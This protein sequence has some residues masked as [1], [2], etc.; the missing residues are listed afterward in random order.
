MG[1]RIRQSL[2]PPQKVAKAREE[3]VSYIHES[4][5]YTKVPRAKAKT[6]G[7]K[8]I[9]VRWIDINKGDNV[10]ENYRSRLVAREIKKDGRPDLFAATPTLE[11]LKVVLSML[12]SSNKGERLMVNDVSRA[13]FCAPARRQV[14]VELPAEDKE[15][16]QDLVGELNYSMYGTRDAA[17]NWGEECAKT[18]KDIGF[19]QGTASPCTFTHKERGIRTYIHGDDYVSVGKE[20]DLMWM[21]QEVEKRYKLKT[22][23]LGPGQHEEQQVRVLNRVLTWT[24]DGILYEADPRH[25]EILIKELG[26]T[27]AKSVCTPGTKEEGRTKEDHQTALRDEEASL[28]RGMTARLNYFAADRPDIAF[29]VKELA[30]TMSAPTKGCWERLKRLTRYLIGKPR[31]TINFGW[32]KIPTKLTTFTDADWAGCKQSR[33]STTGGAIQMGAHTLKTWSKTQSLIA[34]GSG[35]SEFYA[36]LKASAEALGMLAMLK[37]F[38]WHMQGEVYGDASAALGVIN[39]KGW[40]AQ[41]T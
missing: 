9:T 22:Q 36:A 6:A 16:G 30:R 34:L 8:V 10:N 28:Y 35:E 11:A 4:K 32:Q 7:A 41:G 15:E 37:D 3:E 14:F 13:Y 23:I 27:N 26:L 2:G 31:A 19:A 21:K 25:V 40:A 24:K 12:A 20:Q 1:R 29:S 18:M 38:G 5:L 39:R 17:Q 33:K